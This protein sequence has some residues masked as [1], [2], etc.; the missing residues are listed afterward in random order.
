MST[1]PRVASAVP[2]E[3]AH[4]GTALAHQPELAKRFYEDEE[5]YYAIKDPYMDTVYFAAK[6]WG[7]S[8]ISESRD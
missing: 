7:E 4:F 1:I 5:A 3:P 6:V 2:G 8:G